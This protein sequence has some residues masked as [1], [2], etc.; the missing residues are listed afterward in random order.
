[1]AGHLD[2]LEKLNRFFSS[3]DWKNIHQGIALLESLNDSS[4]WHRLIND[5]HINQQGY[6]CIG[7]QSHLRTLVPKDLHYMDIG[8]TFDT[9]DES[10]SDF[11]EGHLFY[12]ANSGLCCSPMGRMIQG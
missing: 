4:L 12:W 5:V 1:M 7:S 2:M 11:G 9:Y 10:G 8:E 6:I 3:R